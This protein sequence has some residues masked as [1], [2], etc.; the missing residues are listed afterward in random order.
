MDHEQWRRFVNDAR[1]EEAFGVVDGDLVEQFFV[2]QI[3]HFLERVLTEHIE[4]TCRVDSEL[5]FEYT[6]SVQI[7]SPLE[8][9]TKF[10]GPLN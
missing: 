8:V 10:L 1:D 4:Q 9:I 7:L 3:S 2:S 6:C 5:H